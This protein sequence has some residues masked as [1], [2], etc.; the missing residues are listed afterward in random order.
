MG[1]SYPTAGD[2]ANCPFK[3]FVFL[4]VVEMACL[5]FNHLQQLRKAFKTVA[6]A[7]SGFVPGGA[8]GSVWGHLRLCWGQGVSGIWWEKTQTLPHSPRLKVT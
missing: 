1:Q 6:P 3:V 5:L 7:Q 2:F 8:C 4:I